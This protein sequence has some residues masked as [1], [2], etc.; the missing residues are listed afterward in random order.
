PIFGSTNPCF[1]GAYAEAAVAKASMLARPPERLSSIEA[2]TVPV[3]SVT[4]LQMVVEIARV[5]P[6]QTVLVLGGAGNVGA[7]A[8]RLA[9]RAG[10]KVATLVKPRD[11]TEAEALGATDIFLDLPESSKPFLD[12]VIDTIGGELAR[13]SAR[14]LRPGGCL[15]SSV[16]RV[17]TEALGRS[18]V[19]SEYLI[20]E[21]TTE[22]LRHVAELLDAGELPVR[23]G[24]VL[25]L[26]SAR[27]AHELM[28]PGT[29]RTPGKIV[30]RTSA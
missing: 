24:T 22:R 14:L 30:L 15:V 7:H 16:K 26:E 23:V 4:A 13:R 1:T 21:I 25:P 28:E 20:V 27:R 29:A 12:V 6:G 2:A 17:D 19:R 9:R 5:A 11:V 10:A 18:D 3:V 8:I